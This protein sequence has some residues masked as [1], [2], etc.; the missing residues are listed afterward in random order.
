MTAQRG[1]LH[2]PSV[3]HLRPT[4][5]GN[6]LSSHRR[7]HTPLLQTKP[8][9]HRPLPSSTMPLQSLSRLSHFS[10]VGLT[11]GLHVMPAPTW[12]SVTPCAQTPGIAVSHGSPPPSQITPSMRNTLSLKSPSFPNQVMLFAPSQSSN[13][14]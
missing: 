8:V 2:S 14:R 13:A 9:W 10:A 7:M 5:Q 3:S 1:S 4:A 11:A 12:H 6:S